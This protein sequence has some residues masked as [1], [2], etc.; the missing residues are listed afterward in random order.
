MDGLLSVHGQG[1]CPTAERLAETD[2][3]RG[4]NKIQGQ[5]ETK[6]TQSPTDCMVQITKGYE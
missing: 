6:L 1:L 4:K 3:V 2:T 5:E